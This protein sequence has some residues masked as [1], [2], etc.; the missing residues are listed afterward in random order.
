MLV[1]E[2]QTICRFTQNISMVKL[3]DDVEF[4]KKIP[5]PSLLIPLLASNFLCW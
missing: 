3:A 4:T 5:K 2:N 1:N